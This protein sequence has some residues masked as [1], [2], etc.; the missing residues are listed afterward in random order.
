MGR[1]VLLPSERSKGG[2]HAHGQV[3]HGGEMLRD[4]A[5]PTSATE[6]KQLSARIMAA[7]ING[8]IEIKTA[9]LAL[10]AGRTFLTAET[11]ASLVPWQRRSAQSPPPDADQSA[12]ILKELSESCDRST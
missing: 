9:R 11:V 6:V 1:H 12:A 5:A 4:V 3:K 7:V 8:T 2:Q 10:L